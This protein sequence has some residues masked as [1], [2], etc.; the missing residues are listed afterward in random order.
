MDSSNYK[1]MAKVKITQ[2]RSKIGS[3][4]RQKKTLEA[5][6]LRRINYSVELENNPQIQGMIKKINHLVKIE[7]V[8]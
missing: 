3:T 5:L 2:V 1:T 6:G 7:E 4:K 8:K